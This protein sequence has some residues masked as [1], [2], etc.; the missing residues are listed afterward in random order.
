MLS[1]YLQFEVCKYFNGIIRNNFN[2][3]MIFWLIQNQNK[4]NKK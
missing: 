1:N 2:P 3:L 4:H